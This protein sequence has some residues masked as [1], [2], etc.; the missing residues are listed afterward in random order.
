[1]AG[2]KRRS[3]PKKQVEN[4]HAAPKA[5]P[6]GGRLAGRVAVVTGGNRGIGLAIAQALV[7]EGCNVLITGRSSTALK[8]AK[9][10]LDA[11]ATSLRPQPEVIPKSCDVRKPDSV[12]AA[13][14]AVK[15]RWGR[16]DILI[17]NAGLSQPMTS[18]EKTPLGL[19]NEVTET[20]LTGLFLCT[21]AGLPLMPSGSI[22]INNLR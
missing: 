3:T 15:K 5:A 9:R 18:V 17:N 20:N 4:D 19:W 7:S 6:S 12:A 14:A 11:L 1:M 13:F 21:R 22:V 8:Q 10:D 16:L 2:K